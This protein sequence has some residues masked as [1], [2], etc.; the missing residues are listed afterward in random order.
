M[1]EQSSNA[2]KSVRNTLEQ[3][4]SLT[5]LKNSLISIKDYLL[6]QSSNTLK[7][8]RNTLEQ[9]FSLT[10]LKNSLI[11]T[12]DFILEKSSLVFKRTRNILEV[13]YN[14]VKRIGSII[15][16]TEAITSIA[17][18]AMS[19]F[20]ASVSGVGKLLGPLAIPLGLVAAGG[21]AALGY[22]LLKGDDVISEGGYGNRTLLTPKVAIALNNEDNIIAGTKLFKKDTISEPK[23]TQSLMPDLTPLLNEMKAMR[24]E[25]SK[26]NTKPTIV[27]NSINS[28]RFGTAVAM[29]TYKTQ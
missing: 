1:I 8:V 9:N 26:A 6:E 7:S 5:K 2:L 28:T 4:F 19:A 18:A 16:K 21:I 14:A 3:N 10:K 15:S 12:K 25:Q 27:E 20:T 17:S 24:Q 13:G 29:N 23:D 22:N 11:S